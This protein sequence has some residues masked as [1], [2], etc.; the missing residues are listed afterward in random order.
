MSKP[1]QTKLS[2]AI[3][4]LMADV[5]KEIDRKKEEVKDEE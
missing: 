1:D 3:D 2:S 4:G 5:V